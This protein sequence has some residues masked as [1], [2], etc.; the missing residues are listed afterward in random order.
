MKNHVAIVGIVI[1]LSAF[2]LADQSI[3]WSSLLASPMFISETKSVS[4]ELT[5]KTL[6]LGGLVSINFDDGF[7]SAYQN[8]W[9]IIK[10]SGLP[11][12]FYIVTNYLDHEGYMTNREVLAMEQAGVEIGAHSRTHPFLAQTDKY[13]LPWQIEGSRTDLL[14]LGVKK[15][16]TFAYPYG[17]ENKQ[18]VEATKKAGFIGARAFDLGLNDKE[19]NPWL[20]H[21][22]GVTL[23]NSWPEIKAEID[24][25]MRNKKWLILVFLLIDED[26]NSISVRHEV[27][28]QVVDYLKEQKILVVTTAEGLRLLHPENL[29][30]PTATSTKSGHSS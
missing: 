27:L 18:V 23:N 11:S 12:T 24:L 3:S 29:I 20:L 1:L 22:W 21:R 15:V 17:S 28:Q 8:G 2:I 26:G 14:K 19:T 5:F 9:P 13:D 10:A 16:E 7:A 4:T 30:T 25:A 6:N